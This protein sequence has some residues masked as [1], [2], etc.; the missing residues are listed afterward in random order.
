VLITGRFRLAR[1]AAAHLKL[2]VLTR[3]QAYEWSL[4]SWVWAA[5][6]R[7]GSGRRTGRIARAVVGAAGAT[8]R[9][10]QAVQ[11]HRRP[12]DKRCPRAATR[13]P[14]R[15]LHQSIGD[16]PY[17]NGLKA[18]GPQWHDGQSRER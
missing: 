18:T 2:D 13:L 6:P 9:S 10:S 16:L 3:D 15:Q 14:E 7:T 8:Q 17:V 5:L 12:S 4:R 11:R 1:L